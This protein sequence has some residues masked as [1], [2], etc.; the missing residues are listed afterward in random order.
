MLHWHDVGIKC[1]GIFTWHIA[2]LVQGIWEHVLYVFNTVDS[3]M[4]L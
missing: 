1:D 3:F 4:V 2:C